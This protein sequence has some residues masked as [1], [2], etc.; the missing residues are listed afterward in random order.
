MADASLRRML[1]RANRANRANRLCCFALRGGWGLVEAAAVG[2]DLLATV[3]L[4]VDVGDYGAEFLG[5]GSL[6]FGGDVV[7]LDYGVGG[8]DLDVEVD[9]VDV[10][11]FAGAEVV[12]CLHAIDS[13]DD[14]PDFFVNVLGQRD[15]EELFHSWDSEAECHYEDKHRDEC[16]GE[17]VEDAPLSSEENRSGDAD[18]RRDTR[19]CVAAVVPCVGDNRHALDVVAHALGVAEEPFLGENRDKRHS[20]SDI[21]GCGKQRAAQRSRD[22]GDGVGEEHQ[23]DNR[24]SNSDE[25]RGKSLEFAVSVAVVFVDALGGDADKYD[26]DDIGDEIAERVD[27][28]GNHSARPADDAGDDFE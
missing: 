9:D 21:A 15:F 28:I 4:D 23:R 11:V 13:G 20:E 25:H 7:R 2:A 27:T 26:H 6:G 18:K 17:G 1:H 5:E 10:A 22:F 19:E 8:I 3:G 12:V 24:K 14:S 16:G